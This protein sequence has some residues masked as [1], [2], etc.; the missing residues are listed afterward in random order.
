MLPAASPAFAAA[1]RQRGAPHAGSIDG[2]NV[3]VKRDAACRYWR[4]PLGAAGWLVALAMLS[5]CQMSPP[6]K[7]APAAVAADTR[8][9]A[10]RAYGAG[11]WPLAET[12]Y[13]AWVATVPDDAEAWFR[14]GNIYARTARPDAAVSAYREALARDGTLGKAWFNMGIVQLRQAAESLHAMQAVL[15]PGDPAAVRG[16]AARAAVMT[17]LDEATGAAPPVE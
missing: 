1:G 9:A 5:A 11:E 17:I 8:A 6:S 14:L 13:R 12:H 10:E 3:H 15:P 16:A 2:K 4:Q 7:A